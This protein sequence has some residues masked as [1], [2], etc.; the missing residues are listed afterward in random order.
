MQV[1]S[2]R[3]LHNNLKNSNFNPRPR[4]RWGIKISDKWKNK[5]ML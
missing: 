3:I 1:L 4:L 5:K 2:I